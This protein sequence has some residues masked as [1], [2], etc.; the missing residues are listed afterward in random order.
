MNSLLKTKQFR[1]MGFHP[2]AHFYS[3][4]ERQGINSSV[5]VRQIM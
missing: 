3:P 4:H 1:A 2:V 5:I